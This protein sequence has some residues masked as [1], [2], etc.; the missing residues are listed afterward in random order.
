MTDLS[1]TPTTISD[2]PLRKM[3]PMVVLLLLTSAAGWLISGVVEEREQRQAETLE[4]FQNSWGPEQI[5]RGPMLVVPYQPAPNRPRRYFEIAPQ[6]LKSRTVLSPEQK[7]RGL[8]HATVYS[9][10]TELQGSFI[11]PQATSLGAEAKLFWEDAVVIVQTTSLSGMT[12]ADHFNWGGTNIF[13]Q[14]CRELI[15]GDD[16]AVSSALAA[17]VPF[18]APPAANTQFSFAA[19]LTLRGTNAFSQAFQ[20]AAIDAAID[21]A[22]ATPSFAGSLLPGESSITDDNF[23]ANWKSADF[24]SPRTWTSAYAVERNAENTSVAKVELLEAT[25]TYRMINRASKYNILFVVLSFTTYL[26]FEL[27]TKLR[28]HALQYGLLGASLTLFALLLVS[29]SE[30]V[31]YDAGYAVSAGLV[32]LQASIYTATVTRRFLHSAMFAAMLGSLFGFL[33]VLLSL[34][35][36]SLLVGSLGLFIVISLLMILTQRVKWFAV[37][38][39]VEA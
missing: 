33:Y 39:T 24:T 36:Y 28:I 5:L 2:F 9:A 37:A 10:S 27:L 4:G 7:K 8:F 3:A 15:S 19:N 6:T 35:T 34:E 17:R 13:W 23:T 16:C 21:G 29:F 20:S 1:P 31:G 26:L 25:P 12:A 14:N 11:I 22:W 32:L 38:P 30:M 18:D